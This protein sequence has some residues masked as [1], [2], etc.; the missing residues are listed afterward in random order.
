VVAASYPLGVDQ[1]ELQGRAAMRTMQSIAWVMVV[2]P[3]LR[4]SDDGHP[5]GVGGR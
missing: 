5:S 3:G 4:I 2:T 1:P